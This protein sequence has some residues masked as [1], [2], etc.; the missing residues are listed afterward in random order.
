MIFSLLTPTVAWSA[1]PAIPP[2]QKIQTPKK[3]NFLQR[4]AVRQLTKKLAKKM[5]KPSQENK[6]KRK[7]G[8]TIFVVMLLFVLAGAVAGTLVA[9]TA[10]LF[11]ANPAFW[12]F[13][14]IGA[15]AGLLF[16]F[17]IYWLL[18][19]RFN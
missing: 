4:W 17:L 8:D 1:A 5:Q 6:R 19:G 14:L 9:L 15:V 13:A 11:G 16:F 10:L 18:T 7:I 3:P 2:T 12:L